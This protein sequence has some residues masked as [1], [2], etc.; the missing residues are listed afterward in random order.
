MRAWSGIVA[1]AVLTASLAAAPRVVFEKFVLNNGLRVLISENHTSPVVSYAVYYNVGSRNEVP[2]RTGFAHLFEHMMFQGSENVG[3]NEHHLWIG[4]AGG[5]DNGSTSNDRTNYFATVPANQLAVALWAEAD[6]MRSLKITAE[7][8]ENQRATV[9]E[10]KKQGQDNQPYA[11]GR[12]R[13]LE[14]L[15]ESFPYRH[16]VIGSTEDLDAAQLPDVQQFFNTY[17]APNNAVLAIV[18]DI[19]PAEARKLVERYFSTIPSQM[20]PPQVIVNEPPRTAEKKVTLVDKY[21]NIPAVFAGYNTVPRGHADNCALILLDNILFNGDSSRLVRRL[22]KEKELAVTING[23]QQDM[24]GAGY[25]SLTMMVNPGKVVG[26]LQ[27]HLGTVLAAAQEEIGRIQKEGVT[28]QE[29]QKARNRI[30]NDLSGITDQ[31]Q[32]LAMRLCEFE[33][34]D[35]DAGAVNDELAQYMAVTAADIV[36]VAK[37]YLVPRNRSVVNVL[38]ASFQAPDESFRKTVPF[39]DQPLAYHFPQALEKTL[40]NGLKIG[41]IRRTSSPRITM[42][43]YLRGGACDEPADRQ[44]ISSV[45]AAM[46]TE[47]SRRYPG[48]TI[49]E[50]LD[51]LGAN[52]NAV[53]T[54]DGIMVAASCLKEAQ[55]EVLDM[56]VDTLLYPQFPAEPLQ[57]RLRNFQNRYTQQRANP[58][59]LAGEMFYRRVFGAHPYAHISIPGN[60]P[61]VN[62]TQVLPTPESLAKIDREQ[63]VDYH[64]RFFV[65]N[66]SLLVAIGDVDPPILAQQLEKALAVWP[67]GPAVAPADFPVPA[68][69]TKRTLYLI[70]RPGSVQSYILMGN[71]LFPRRHESYFPLLLGNKILGGGRHIGGGGFGRLF[72]NIR[73]EKGWTYGAYSWLIPFQKSGVFLINT[74]VRTDVTAATVKEI[75]KEIARIHQGDA[76]ADDIRYTKAFLGSVLPLTQENPGA[77]AAAWAELSLAGL[78]ADYWN[79]Y[80]GKIH[81][82]TMEQMTAA[83]KQYMGLGDTTLVIVGD[84]AKIQADLRPLCDEMKVFD[85]QGKEK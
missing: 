32:R 68:R 29:L 66:G 79:A 58:L 10:E 7:N 85:T 76:S 34:F 84:A 83:A 50:R 63:L 21:A 78:P 11:E 73:E 15:F 74:E 60:A 18:G 37:T 80:A 64:K 38:P 20:P 48:T 9:K 69:T 45:L 12:N 57:K 70:D 24:R 56:L 6:R 14:L 8:F 5:N 75:Y 62:M 82:V 23:G 40:A 42:Q 35:N 13:L 72:M 31:T 4:R 44:G 47:G 43:V 49:Q 3:R 33:L 39:N 61:Y 16:T 2:G 53:A 28:P 36:R 17:Y 22:V 59:F 67:Q 54:P 46:L 27:S 52:L 25:F 65:P 41:I 26:D 1:F 51:F 30:R 77:V 71:V 81:A 55:T 19:R